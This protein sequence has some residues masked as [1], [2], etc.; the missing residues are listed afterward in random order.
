MPG[1]ETT[2]EGVSDSTGIFSTSNLQRV[3]LQS[4]GL[5]SLHL[6]VPPLAAARGHRP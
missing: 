3:P 4:R 6:L 1:N 2:C 5:L